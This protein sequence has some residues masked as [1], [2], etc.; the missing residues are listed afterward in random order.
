MLGRMSKWAAKSHAVDEGPLRSQVHPGM[1]NLSGV[2]VNT[3][4]MQRERESTAKKIILGFRKAF[5]NVCTYVYI[6]LH[7]DRH[8]YIRVCMCTCIPGYRK[9]R[10]LQ[11]VLAVQFL[12]VRAKLFSC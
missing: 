3:Y 11:A 2:Y 9:Q 6:H 5:V 4:I 8:A 12:T 10:D 1:W 7:T